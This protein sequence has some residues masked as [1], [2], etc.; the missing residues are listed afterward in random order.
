[1]MKKLLTGLATGFL[2]LCIVGGSNAA[3]I[4]LDDFE[5]GTTT[6]WLATNSGGGGSNGVE[7][8][9]ESNWAFVYKPRSGKDSL[10]R[11]FA[12]Q[13]D[14][15]LSFDMQAL[16]NGGSTNGGN[17]THAASGVTISFESKFNVTLGEVSFGFATSDSL[18][19]SNAFAVSNTPDSYEARL[20]EW[21]DLAKVDPMT[22]IADIA[23]EFWAIGRTANI[24]RGSAATA[25]VR[26][27]NVQFQV[28]PVPA[29]AWLLG[30]GLIGLAGMK[31]LKRRKK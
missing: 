9:N 22:D 31:R 25:R 11:E 6:G 12:Y 20:S 8:V 1:M 21:A 24:P 23:L 3:T 16:A 10:S 28:V 4:F 30:S 5:D 7:F 26:F 27:D 19:P 15:V 18:L 29:A 17:P 14:Y 2:V 13:P